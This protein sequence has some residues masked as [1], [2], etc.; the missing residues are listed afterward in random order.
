MIRILFISVLF[1]L[2]SCVNQHYCRNDLCYIVE[3]EYQGYGVFDITVMREFSGDFED[4]REI[5]VQSIAL[6]CSS[7]SYVIRSEDRDSEREPIILISEGKHGG[8][9]YFYSG[10][11][12]CN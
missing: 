2:P 11:A 8:T 6:E 12:S 4:M 10:V 3:I 5:M 1:I 7:K 9:T